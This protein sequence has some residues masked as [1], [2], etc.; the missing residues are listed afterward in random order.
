MHR[1]FFL[2]WRSY[3]RENTVTATNAE[4]KLSLTIQPAMIL[5]LLTS[6]TLATKYSAS[7]APATTTTKNTKSKQS[8]QIKSFPFFYF[9]VSNLSD[10][11]PYYRECPYCRKK[12]YG[13]FEK[14]V[15]K[16]EKKLPKW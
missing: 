10:E 16:C 6:V 2:D 5:N 1:L 7:P 15:A 11:E 3:G 9:G 4:T 8:I 12:I 14:H 13:N